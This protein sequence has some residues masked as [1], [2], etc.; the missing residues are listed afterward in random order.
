MRSCESCS[1]NQYAGIE[2]SHV[3]RELSANWHQLVW[4][5]DTNGSNRA[6]GNGGVLFFPAVTLFQFVS[7]PSVCVRVS[8]S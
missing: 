2:W 8:N 4:D 7:V 1:A 6:D 3:S 5:A